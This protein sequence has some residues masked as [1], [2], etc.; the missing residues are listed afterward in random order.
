MRLYLLISQ[1]SFFFSERSQPNLGFVMQAPA[2]LLPGG[3]S[4]QLPIEA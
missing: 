4:L 2:R 3:Q 1:R